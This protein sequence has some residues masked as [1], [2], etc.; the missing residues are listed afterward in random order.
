M[1]RQGRHSVI[2]AAVLAAAAVLSLPSPGE[3][4]ENGYTTVTG[5]LHPRV[6]V[7][8]RLD[9]E[10]HGDRWFTG[11]VGHR[12]VRIEPVNLAS[13][14]VVGIPGLSPSDGTAM[15]PLRDVVRL[16]VRDRGEAEWTPLD[17][18]PLLEAEPDACADA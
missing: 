1:N 6:E 13:C 7:R 17:P 15:V 12:T 8:V 18:G 9:P 11:T 4:Q 16:Q 10:E 5:R 2:L 14:T 3:A